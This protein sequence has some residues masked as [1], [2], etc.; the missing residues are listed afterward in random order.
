[1]M[2]DHGSPVVMNDNRPPVAM[3]DDN[4]FFDRS[5]NRIGLKGMRRDWRG[6]GHAGHHGETHHGGDDTVSEAF[7]HF[8]VI[9]N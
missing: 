7:Q 1:M 5:P 2:D 9:K 3:H 8:V 6:F 4:R